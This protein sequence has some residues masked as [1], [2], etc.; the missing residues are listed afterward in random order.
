[1][2]YF[3]FESFEATRDKFV[4]ASVV[5]ENLQRAVNA[6]AVAVQETTNSDLAPSA[7]VEQ[8]ADEV[9]SFHYV[10]RLGVADDIFTGD[11]RYLAHCCQNAVF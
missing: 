1:V 11:A 6:G 5:G 9:S 8:V 3:G 4:P 2:C 7:Q 10:R